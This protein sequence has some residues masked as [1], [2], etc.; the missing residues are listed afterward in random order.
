MFTPEPWCCSASVVSGAKSLV[1][2]LNNFF[3]GMV[4]MLVGVSQGWTARSGYWKQD[5]SSMWPQLNVW[6]NKLDQFRDIGKQ[7]TL[8]SANFRISP[9][10]S[11]FGYT[12]HQRFAARSLFKAEG[13]SQSWK[14][15]R[16]KAQCNCSR[17]EV[18]L[19]PKCNIFTTPPIAIALVSTCT[20]WVWFW[21]YHVNKVL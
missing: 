7:S 11:D 8:A 19:S 16:L 3:D 2:I 14:R 9:I 15:R 17:L 20:P 1:H 18:L 12:L 13:L 4:T 6:K 5:I 10:C 21:S